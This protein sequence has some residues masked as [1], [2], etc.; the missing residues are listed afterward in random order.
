M[1]TAGKNPYPGEE[2][3]RLKFMGMGII[4]PD[5]KARYPGG[6]TADLKDRAYFKAA[7]SGKTNYSDIIISRV[8]NSPVMMLA[9]PVKSGNGRILGVLLARLDGDWLSQ[10]TDDV[11]FG[12]Q[13]YSYI[14]NNKGVLVAHPDRKKVMARKNHIED[15]K[16]D[17]TLE[18]VANHIST[19][20]EK[21]TGFNEYEFNGTR[22]VGG[23]SPIEG[24]SWIVAV[25]TEEKELFQGIYRIRN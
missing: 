16:T 15:A 9:T 13:G 17:K 3:R 12:T 5:G 14:V 8:T 19:M 21:K 2:T 23:F 18:S 11:K 6:K 7:M 22:W 1:G 4:M 20:I 24:T 10:V 25:V